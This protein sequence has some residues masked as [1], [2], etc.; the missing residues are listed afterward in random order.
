MGELSSVVPSGF[1]V[2][3]LFHSIMGGYTPV[4]EIS[5]SPTAVEETK[6]RGH[7]PRPSM[8]PLYHRVTYLLRNHHT[9]DDRGSS[10]RIEYLRRFPH[11]RTSCGYRAPYLSADDYEVILNVHVGE[12]GK[13]YA[14]L[15]RCMYYRPR[16]DISSPGLDHE[17][18][19]PFIL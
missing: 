10:V 17:Y 7:Y 13:R 11:P 9:I 6:P 15:W 18:G 16:T 8:M 1:L 3:W 12:R 4:W 5:S 2:V 19:G 14:H